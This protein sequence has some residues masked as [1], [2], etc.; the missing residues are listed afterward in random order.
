MV[1]IVPVASDELA[2]PIVC[3]RFASRIIPPAPAGISAEQRD[4][5]HGDGDR[6]RDGEPDPQAEVGVGGAEDDAEDDARPTT[7]RT[8]NSTTDSS[9]LEVGAIIAVSCLSESD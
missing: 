3:E 7:A 9:G 1:K 5:Q 4:R 6:R 2:E 8:V